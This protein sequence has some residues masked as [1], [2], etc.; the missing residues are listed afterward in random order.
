[1]VIALKIRGLYAP[2]ILVKSFDL[3]PV[4][5]SL[6]SSF[7]SGVMCS[8]TRAQLGLEFPGHV[9]C[10]R[11]C[12]R[13]WLEFSDPGQHHGLVA[14]ADFMSAA[15]TL[16]PIALMPRPCRFKSKILVSRLSAPR[17]DAQMLFCCSR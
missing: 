7:C 13:P 12:P 5:S 4:M 3:R 15:E 16:F 1:M 9:E 10:S 17:L 6:K 11:A 14:C 2:S 8:R